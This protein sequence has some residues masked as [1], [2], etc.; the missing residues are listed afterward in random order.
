MSAADSPERVGVIYGGI[1]PED[2]ELLGMLAHRLGRQ[3]T[4]MDKNHLITMAYEGE[5][6]VRD[7]GPSLQ[8]RGVHIAASIDGVTS[9]D[10]YITRDH[11]RQFGQS[12]LGITPA[13]QVPARA[14]HD[15][16]DTR[17]YKWDLTT[18]KY[19]PVGNKIT[20]FPGIRTARIADNVRM[21]VRP[22]INGYSAHQVAKT[23]I[24]GNLAIEVGSLIEA[25]H[26][27]RTEISRPATREFVLSIISQVR[28][29]VSAA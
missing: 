6:P 20:P 2:E 17:P 8:T 15:L 11:F 13:K 12:D 28:S 29:Q 4:F 19:L 1:T 26:T 7:E 3:C 24:L 21:T 22:D 16:V 10:D 9:R 14:F 27:A 25:E 5:E 18:R 23:T